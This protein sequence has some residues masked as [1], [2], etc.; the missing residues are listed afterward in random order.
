MDNFLQKLKKWVS[1]RVI[2]TIL[3]ANQ[4]AEKDGRYQL[5]YNYI[6]KFRTARNSMPRS[7][8]DIM[9]NHRK[10]SSLV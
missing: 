10:D 4:I 5:P 3:L 7:T 1:Y 2:R 8:I 9:G 6:K